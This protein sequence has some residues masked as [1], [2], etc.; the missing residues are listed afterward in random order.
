MV[1][2]VEK[3]LHSTAILPRVDEDASVEHRVHV[4][5]EW[6]LLLEVGLVNRTLGMNAKNVKCHVRNEIENLLTHHYDFL[7]L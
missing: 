3:W 1:V 2:R 4:S 6:V 7:G 5:A